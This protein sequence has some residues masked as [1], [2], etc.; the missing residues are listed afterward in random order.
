MS[1]EPHNHFPEPAILNYLGLPATYSPSP[2]TEP[3]PFLRAHFHQLP[4]H[5]QTQ[6]SAVTDPK[7]RTVIPTIRNRRLKYTQTAP[8]ELQFLLARN[9]WPELWPV[10][11]RH[12][13]EEGRDE[14]EWVEKEFLQGQKGHVGKLGGL[15]GDY[16]EEREADRVR[17][18]MRRRALAGD[19]DDFIPEEDSD[20]EGGS[21][22]ALEEEPL[23]EQKASFERL[24]RERFI[25]GLL[26]V[27]LVHVR[28]FEAEHC[29]ASRLTMTPLIGM[30]LSMW[31]T[32]KRKSGGLMRIRT[33]LAPFLEPRNLIVSRFQCHLSSRVENKSFV[34]VTSAPRTRLDRP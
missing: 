13:I 15:L 5:L 30:S 29:I 33:P 27:R 34:T 31:K 18:L 20:E 6:F 21:Q 9:A 25:Y 28:F 4:P 2:S 26:E 22:P 10:R 7:Q 16:E 24:V 19:D 8:R 32:G 17:V 11:E 23:E 14:R 3:I 12:G 1:S